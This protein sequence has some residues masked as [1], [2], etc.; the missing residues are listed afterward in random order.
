MADGAG[1]WAAA[2]QA[3]AS[4]PLG[5]RITAAVGAYYYSGLD[6][7]QRPFHTPWGNW[8]KWS[9]L[10][11]YSL[12]GEST[13]GR[14]H[15]A[16]WENVAAPRVTLRRSVTRWL[17]ARLGVDW[18][19]APEPDWTSRGVL[20]QVE[21]EVT[22][23]RAGLTG[24]LLMERLAP[25]AFHHGRHGLPTLTDAVRFLRWQLS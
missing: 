22:G 1:G 18:L 21:L 15:V 7:T 5:G 19:L 25:G 12:L 4:R 3:L 2:G 24:H 23:K 16:A 9:E 20:T 11:I 6:G 8:P 10:Y 14:P 17:D 13:P